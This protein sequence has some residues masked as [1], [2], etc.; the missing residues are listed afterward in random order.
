MVVML[1]MPMI[2]TPLDRPS[3]PIAI[4]MLSFYSLAR[5]VHDVRGLVG[6]LVVLGEMFVDYRWFDDR[7]H[8]W[9]DVVFVLALA[10][11]PYVLGRVIRHLAEQKAELERAQ[12]AIRDQVARDERDRIARELHD[13]LAHSLSA[14]SVQAAAAQDLI[15]ADPGRAEVIIGQVSS[16]GR[17]ALS[18]TAHLLRA[19]RDGDDE[20]GMT[21]APGLD[22]ISELV[23]QFRDEGLRVDVEQDTLPSVPAEIDISAYRIV[24]EILTNA[25]RYAD[26]PVSLRIGVVDGGRLGISTSNASSGRSGAGTGWGLLGMAE[27]ISLLGGTLA[28]RTTDQGRFELVAVLPVEAS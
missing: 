22:Q 18:E 7:E 17:R 1:G 23:E 27:R 3:V 24:Q 16:T 20:L 14:M 25:L 13:I 28:R 9:S 2:G 10:T 8:D 21:P 15:H 5:Y 12:A 6:V 11:P 19:L 26:G 4:W